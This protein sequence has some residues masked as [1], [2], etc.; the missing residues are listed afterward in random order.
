[1]DP[2]VSSQPSLSL[3]LHVGLPPMGH[4]HSHHQAAPMIALAKP[5][6]LVEENFMPLKKDPEV[7]T[8]AQYRTRQEQ[9]DF[10]S[11]CRCRI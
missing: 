8:Y 10:D 5:K 7:G 11:A 9:R 3:D 1:M 2:W 6:V 4:P